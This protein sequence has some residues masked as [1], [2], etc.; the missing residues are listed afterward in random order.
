MLVRVWEL[1]MLVSVLDYQN[2]PTCSAI[3]TGGDLR[4]TQSLSALIALSKA[5]AIERMDL[6]ERIRNCD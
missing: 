4:H 6:L 1:P 2:F 5:E 3:L